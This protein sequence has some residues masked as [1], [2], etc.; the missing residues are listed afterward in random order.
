MSYCFCIWLIERI[1]IKKYSF[2]TVNIFCFFINNPHRKVIYFEQKDQVVSNNLMVILISKE[3]F[4][5]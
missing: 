3:T 5:K 1:D 2:K 4:V